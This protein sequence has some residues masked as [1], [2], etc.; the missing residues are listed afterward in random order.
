MYAILKSLVLDVKF[1]LFFQRLHT[2]AVFNFVLR[3]YFSDELVL[4]IV[5]L[6]Q[7]N[8]GAIEVRVALLAYRE[9]IRYLHFPNKGFYSN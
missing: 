7:Y 1:I 3:V 6:I 9:Y 2:F 4:I 5:T 8:V